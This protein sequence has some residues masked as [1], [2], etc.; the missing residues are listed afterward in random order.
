MRTPTSELIVRAAALYLPI[1]IAIA[2][3]I[4]RRPDRRCIAAAVVAVAWNVVMLLAANILAQHFG[5]WAF[6]TSTAA[7]AGTPADLWIGW[8]LLWG[9]VPLL[10]ISE[11]LVLVG[12]VLIAADLVMMPLAAPVVSLRSTWLIGELLCVATCLVPGLILGRWTVRD[13]HV[14]R[15]AA[16]QVVAFGGLLLFVV[17]TL[18]FAITG[19]DWSALVQ[20]PRWQLLLAAL[21]AAPAGSMALQAV[22]EFAVAG[23]GT[24]VPLDPPRRLVVTG[25]Y[26]YVAN[27]MQVGATFL[28]AEWGVLLASPAVVAAAVMGALFSAGVA[29]WNEGG[30]LTHRFGRGWAR[31]RAEVRLW[32]PSWRPY[33]DTT[34]RVFVGTTCEPCSDVGRFLGRRL[35]AG[36]GIVAA[37]DSTDEMTRITYRASGVGTETG[38]AAVGRSVEHINLVWAV[39][40]WI[41]RLPLVR[42]LLQLVA[43]AVGAGPRQLSRQGSASAGERSRAVGTRRGTG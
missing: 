14:R 18:I 42:P 26:A 23:D 2:L 6:S 20:R 22:R 17:P 29:A 36:L 34:A 9:A 7:V 5:W 10:I 3:V 31:Y 33:T 15:R 11:R 16:L 32:L 13:H 12:V 43:D 8:A 28:L 24:P 1:T 4:H 40:S 35:P 39:C 41:V 27:P 21:V 37:E 25:P 30:E 38:L 19:E